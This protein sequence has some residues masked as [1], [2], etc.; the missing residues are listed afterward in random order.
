MTQHLSLSK[1]QCPDALCTVFQC[2]A[3][4]LAAKSTAPIRDAADNASNQKINDSP[5]TLSLFKKNSRWA[6]YKSYHHKTCLIFVQIE[7]CC[8]TQF[9]T[10]GV[11]SRQGLCEVAI[12]SLRYTLSSL[13]LYTLSSTCTISTVK[14]HSSYPESS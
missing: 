12:T 1:K 9:M 4:N 10:K 3:I 8:R 11:R 13:V 7:A 2:T 6:N 14:Y 5:T